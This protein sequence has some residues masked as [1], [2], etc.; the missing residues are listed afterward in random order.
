M[1][2]EIRLVNKHRCEKCGKVFANLMRLQHHIAADH[3]I[4]TSRDIRTTRNIPHSTGTGNDNTVG[5]ADIPSGLYA[6]T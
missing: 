1:T 4:R 3:A 5:K 6:K 2:R